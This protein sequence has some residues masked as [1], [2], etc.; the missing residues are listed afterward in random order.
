MSTININGYNISVKSSYEFFN[1]L[2]GLW[3]E[4]GAVRQIP[5]NIYCFGTL[6]FCIAIAAI[7]LPIAWLLSHVP[8]IWPEALGAMVGIICASV[9]NNPYRDYFRALIVSIIASILLISNVTFNATIFGFHIEKYLYYVAIIVSLITLWRRFFNW[10]CWHLIDQI[11]DK[12][13]V[14]RYQQNDLISAYNHMATVTNYDGKSFSSYSDAMAA[15]TNI[16]NS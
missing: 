7:S 3:D 14:P 13:Q 1:G 6:A 15:K 11:C 16:N 4:T 8:F 9:G 10:F 12:Y 2:L 5:R